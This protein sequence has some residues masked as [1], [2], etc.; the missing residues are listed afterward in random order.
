M[1]KLS[2]SSIAVLMLLVAAGCGGPGPEAESGEAVV[3]PNALTPEEQ[4]KGWRLL[5]DGESL[6]GWEDPAMENPPGD[7][8]TVEEGCIK[9]VHAP[10]LREDLFTLDAFQDFE[11]SFEWKISP[12]GNSG[13]KY[14]VQDRG[15]LEDGKLNPDAKR[16]E[17]L[18]DYELLHRQ[19]GRDRVTPGASFQEYVVAFEYQ[20]IDNNAHKDALRG[21]DRTSGAIYSM[22]APASSPVKP[23]GEFN[24]SRIVL[25]GNHVQHW[26]NGEK[27]VDAMLDSEPIVAGLEKRWGQESPVYRLLTEMPRKK[28]PIGLQHHVDEA[29]YRSIKIRPL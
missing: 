22:V 2:F 18:V 11:L 10:K 1:L 6:A 5:F 3:G 26:L 28:S 14:R 4:A 13:V 27:V 17:D 9:A 12:G 29:W 25:R 23:V 21:A 24:E 8:W 7:A 20:V 15:V 16:F 19:S